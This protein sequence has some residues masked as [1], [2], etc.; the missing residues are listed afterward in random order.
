MQK[1]LKIFH[2]PQNPCFKSLNSP[3]SLVLANNWSLN[4]P[5]EKYQIWFCATLK[6]PQQTHFHSGFVSS[7]FTIAVCRVQDLITLISVYGI[8]HQMQACFFE[9]FCWSGSNSEHNIVS[10]RQASLKIQII[11]S[12]PVSSLEASNHGDWKSLTS[13]QILRLSPFT[14]LFPS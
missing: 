5:S 11:H 8:S 3:H 6:K 12:L 1:A 10:I 4:S 2:A 13:V 7:F 9:Q 14:A